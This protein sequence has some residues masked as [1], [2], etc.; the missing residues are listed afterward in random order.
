M[1]ARAVESK[2]TLHKRSHFIRILEHEKCRTP[3][4]RRRL[5][6]SL[7]SRNACQD[8]TKPLYT[9]IYWKNAGA[10]SEHPDQ[11]PAFTATVRTP[12]CGHTVGRTNKTVRYHVKCEAVLWISRTQPVKTS[13]AW[14]IPPP[15]RHWPLL[16]TEHCT[17]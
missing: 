7:R 3:K 12:Q 4:P 16:A 1:R 11:A 9:E 6:A 14:H 5:Y 2:A 10:Q 15:D 13:D 8:F 17:K